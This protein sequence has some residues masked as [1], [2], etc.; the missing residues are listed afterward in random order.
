MSKH[1][2]DII[3]SIGK[4]SHREEIAQSGLDPQLALL[5]VWQAE[6]LAHTYADLLDQPRYRPACLFFLEDI[7]AARDFTQRDHDLETMYEFMRRFVPEVIS[8]PAAL[9][10]KLHRMTEVLDRQLLEVLVKQLGVTD[11][12]TVEQYA[13]GYRRCDNYRERV[14]QIEAIMEICEHIDGL[15]RNPITGPVLSLAKRPLRAAGYGEVVAFLERGYDS[16]KR[17][18]GSRHFRKTLH[19]REMG[20]LDRFYAQDPDPFRFEMSAAPPQK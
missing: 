3:N 15:V 7:Y 10:I 17:M 5:R 12:I 8:R 2:H 1:I 13:E 9:T 14:V 11:S 16:F 20:I 4:I 18:H 19:D 6:R